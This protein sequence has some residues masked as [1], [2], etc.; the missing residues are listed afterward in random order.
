METAGI[1][2]DIDIGADVIGSDGKKLGTVEYVVVQPPRMHVTD[3]VVRTGGLLTRDVVIPA[4]AVEDVEDGT[5]YLSIHKD[6]LKSYPDFVEV[7]YEKPPPS[8]VPPT[9]F[10]YPPAAVLLPPTAGVPEFEEVRV[11]VPPG[12]RAIR[13]GM[14]VETIDGDKV[15]KVGSL[16]LELP[17]GDVKGFVVEQGFL[18]KRD[19]R[20]PVSDVKEIR[21]DKVILKLTKEQIERVEREQ[22]QLSD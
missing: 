21:D 4:S 13:E 1:V 7:H 16:D 5:V 2:K 14:E 3:I 12:T 9:D 20:I 18:F 6:D 17:T 22:Q 19:T 8:W 10:Y 11:N 15:G